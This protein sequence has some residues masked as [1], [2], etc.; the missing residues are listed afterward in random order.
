MIDLIFCSWLFTVCSVFL[1]PQWNSN[2][3]WQA[4]NL[5]GK[6]PLSTYTHAV[7]PVLLLLLG[8][9]SVLA[10]LPLSPTFLSCLARI[11]VF[12]ITQSRS[13]WFHATKFPLFAFRK[14]SGRSPFGQSVDCT[15]PTSSKCCR[16][17]PYR[18]VHTLI[19]DIY[20]TN[21][22]LLITFI[23]Y[24]V[25]LCHPC[26]YESNWLFANHFIQTALVFSTSKPNLAGGI[27]V[28]FWN[29]LAETI[30]KLSTNYWC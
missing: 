1:P 13:A 8:I 10:A 19:H 12:H 7:L 6:H 16:P 24:L 26:F 17:H 23:K 27:G 29:K 25:L 11:S 9:T 15:T 20:H 18:K 30:K 2:Y 4:G 14:W 22:G 3:A 21:I 28:L 5:L